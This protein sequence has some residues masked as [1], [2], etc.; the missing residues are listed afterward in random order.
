MTTV[1]WHVE[2]LKVTLKYPCEVTEFTHNLSKIYGYKLM[3]H[4]LKVHDYLGMN[5]DYSK[6]GVA[7]ASIIKH[8]QKVLDK[9]TE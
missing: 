9:F 7:K 3:V 6:T 1:V 4:R 5:L 2:D 8:L